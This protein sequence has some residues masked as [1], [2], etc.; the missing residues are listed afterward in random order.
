MVRHNGNQKN[1]HKDEETGLWVVSKNINRTNEEGVRKL[2]NIVFGEFRTFR[3][4]KL[5]RDKLEKEG[6]EKYYPPDIKYPAKYYCKNSYGRYDIIK[7]GTYYG[8]VRNKT[9][10]EQIVHALKKVDFDVDKLPEWWIEEL[11]PYSESKYY[12]K[13]PNGKFTVVK[14]MNI[15]GKRR[16]K[17]FG[18]FDT[19]EEA[20]E[21]VYFLKKYNWDLDK[22][23]ETND[24]YI[25]RIKKGRHKYYYYNNNSNKWCVVKYINNKY[26]YFGEYCTEEEAKTRVDE[27]IIVNWDTDKL[28]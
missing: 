17:Y 14:Q 7:N 19:E 28:K 22:L 23:P 25:L 24:E 27:L 2:V 5:F 12:I 26:V 4:A 8:T 1:I 13:T 18:T 15:N 9:L 6:Y 11:K 21:R 10:A 20:Q 3:E 16:V